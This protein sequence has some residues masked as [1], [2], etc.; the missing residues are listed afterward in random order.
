MIRTVK[1]WR[2]LSATAVVLAA[3]EGERFT[4]TNAPFPINPKGS[5]LHGNRT[6][7][8]SKRRG[9]NAGPGSKRVS[10]VLRDA[11]FEA[12][13][14]LADQQHQTIGGTAEDLI[15]ATLKADAEGE[16]PKE[17]KRF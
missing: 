12:L 10:V 3:A 14:A 4:K 2:A 1:E 8:A 6:Y 9:G 16:T 13:R 17:G 11:D 15:E 5:V 7:P